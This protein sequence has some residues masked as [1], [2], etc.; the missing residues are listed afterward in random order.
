MW[1]SNCSAAQSRKNSKLFLRSISV[2]PLG[3]EALQFDRTDFRAVLLLLAAPL[4]LLVVVQLALDPSIARWKRL[5]LD[6]SRSAEIGF[7]AGVAQEG[8]EGVEDIDDGG[9]DRLS[10]R[11]RPGSGSSSKGRNP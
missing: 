7:E 3:G 5:T 6:Q 9:D 1:C 10:F 4:R 8:D 11:Q 2:I